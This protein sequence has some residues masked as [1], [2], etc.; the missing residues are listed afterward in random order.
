MD[1]A[2]TIATAATS[3]EEWEWEDRLTSFEDITQHYRLARC[4]LPL[5][6]QKLYKRQAV[7]WRQLQT[8][9][10]PNPVILNLCYPELYA[11][12]CEFC[13]ARAILEHMLWE[14]C[15]GGAPDWDATSNRTR[16]ESALLSHSLEDKLWA[17][18]GLRP[19]PELKGLWP[20]P[21]RAYLPRSL[22][23]SPDLFK[24]KLRFFLNNRLMA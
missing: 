10:F 1:R 16:W 19:P 13:E 4:K 22:N 15:R 8:R 6:H 11:S 23:N 2:T 24:I 5:P 20:I 14:C 9:T 3:G 21:R 18:S 12:R 17:S 7:T